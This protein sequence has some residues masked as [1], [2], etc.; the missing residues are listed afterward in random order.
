MGVGRSWVWAWAWRV[1]KAAVIVDKCERGGFRPPRAAPGGPWVPRPHLTL[2]PPTYT[3]IHAPPTYTLILAPPS[4]THLHTPFSYAHL[5]TRLPHRHPYI[6]LV[7]THSTHGLRPT[8]YLRTDL[9]RHSHS[10]SQKT[11]HRHVP[12]IRTFLLT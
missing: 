9:C 3:P 7:R 6:H 12:F 10:Q 4:Y 8:Q 2:H 11:P 1:Q 5:Y